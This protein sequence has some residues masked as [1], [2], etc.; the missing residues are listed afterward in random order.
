MSNTVLTDA[1][2]VPVPQLRNPLTQTF[3]ELYGRQA[4]S[5]VVRA[6]FY[7]V[8]ATPAPTAS[9]FTLLSSSGAPISLSTRMQAQLVGSTL[10]VLLGGT[11]CKAIVIAAT[12]SAQVTLDSALPS[13][14]TAGVALLVVPPDPVVQ[15]G[16][17]APLTAA[18][19][20][21]I[22]TIPYSDITVASGIT[23]VNVTGILHRNARS[24]AFTVI[25]GLNV[26]LT[27]FQM[28]LFDSSIQ[29]TTGVGDWWGDSGSAQTSGMQPS[30]MGMVTST[31]STDGAIGAAV[32]SVSF[33]I[34]MGATLPG[35]GNLKIYATEQ[36]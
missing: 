26:A 15:T 9:V 13:A 30:S 10:E 28:Q 5:S 20:T 36:F 23:R 25:Q 14:P 7:Q 27:S 32:D 24:R 21:L 12:A 16:S 35:S 18:A 33:L 19:P 22:A 34:G 17:L 31:D 8:A 3:E 1:N 2:G 4:A 6:D 11:L 29:G